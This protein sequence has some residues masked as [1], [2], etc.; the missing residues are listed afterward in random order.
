MSRALEH[1]LSIKSAL[2]GIRV[3]HNE[4]TL[5]HRQMIFWL[6]RTMLGGLR[7]LPVELFKLFN[8][9]EVRCFQ[10]IIFRQILHCVLNKELRWLE[11]TR[12]N[13]SG[14]G[15]REGRGEWMERMVSEH[16]CSAKT[17]KGSHN[18]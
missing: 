15:G 7:L 6:E 18:L 17:T 14:S 10:A 2:Q 8:Q 9:G 4:Q 5:T 16:I 13:E 3:I 11:H 1:H 12:R